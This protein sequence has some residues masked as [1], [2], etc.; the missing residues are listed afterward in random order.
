MRAALSPPNR[1]QPHEHGVDPQALRRAGRKARS[2]CALYRRRQGRAGHRDLGT[3]RSPLDPPRRAKARDAFP[4]H[5]GIGVP[6]LTAPGIEMDFP[7]KWVAGRP[8]TFGCDRKAA[9]FRHEGLLITMSVACQRLR[10]QVGAMTRYGQDWRVTDM[11]L[12]TNIRFTK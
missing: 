2:S 7:L 11:V 3:R 4:S 9:L 5:L 8:R 6:F 1:G 12:S 10:H